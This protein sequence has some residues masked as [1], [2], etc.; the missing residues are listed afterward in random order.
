MNLNQ[1]VIVIT[2]ATRT[3]IGTFK[4]S[5]KNMLGHEI[6]SVAIKDAMQK[7]NLKS[8]DVDEL[9]MGQVLTGAAG[10]NPARQAAIFSGL[11]YSTHCMTI[12]KVCVAGM[13]A[14]ML[15]EQNIRLNQSMSL[16]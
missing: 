16:Y 11:L 4:G 13:K 7:S 10:Q 6:G 1:E 2:S 15:A 8:N 14:I 12:Y 3:A 9:I 5:L